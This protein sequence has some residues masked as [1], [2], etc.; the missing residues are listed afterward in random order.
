MENG[1]KKRSW[2]LNSEVRQLRREGRPG[3]GKV[4]Q[5]RARTNKEFR[6]RTRRK[7]GA[8]IGEIA[9][10]TDWQNHGIRGFIS[11]TLTK[12]MGLTVESVKS[13]TGDR[14][15]RIA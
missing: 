10:A 12:K 3:G 2:P 5:D 6:A 8:T 9:K 11:G 14:T 15:Y 1:G 7:E 13:D 4:G